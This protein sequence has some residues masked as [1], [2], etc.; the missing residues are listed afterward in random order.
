MFKYNLESVKK[1]IKKLGGKV[2]SKEYK[3]YL[4]PIIIKCQNNHIWTT[5]YH[6]IQRGFWCPDCAGNRKYTYE[7]VKTAIEFKGG[8]LLSKKYINN[9]CILKIKCKNKHSWNTSFHNIQRGNWC[10]ECG[11]GNTQKK[12]LDI[13]RNI[14][15][16]PKYIVKNN[17]REFP[18]LLNKKTGRRQEIDIFIY[19]RNKIFTLA[20]EY[21]GEQHFY[22][23]NF[24]GK[25]EEA[26]IQFIKTKR[27][28]RRKNRL[29]KSHKREIKYF[30]RFNYKDDITINGVLEKLK[31]FKIKEII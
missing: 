7:Y 30:I 20:I 8:M 22:P 5:N 27:R 2:L 26:L 25:D 9:K 24:G 28:D 11:Y 29:L 3:N 4:T 16:Y 13:L 1:I 18:W 21:D 23:V 10:P 14:F 12:L 15:P 17:Y 19:D 6:N 31:K